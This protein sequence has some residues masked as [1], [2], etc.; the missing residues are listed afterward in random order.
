MATDLGQ[1]KS[2]SSRHEVF[3]EEQLRRV[4]N[5]IRLYDTATALLGFLFLTLTWVLGIVL[6]DRLLGMA[7]GTR[8][9]AWGLYA[10]VAALY[11]GITVVRPFLRPINPYFA[12]R[13]VE[14]VLPDA[15][16]SVINWLDLRQTK[17]PPA[18]HHSLGYRAARDLTDLD[19]DRTLSPRQTA[20]LGVL[21]VV[22]G[23]ALGVSLSMFRPTS[24]DL[25]EPIDR[26]SG[27]H[28][29]T[30]PMHQS[31]SFKVRVG[32]RVPNP[33]NPDRALKLLLRYHDD[34]P[35]QERPLER[36]DSDR[37]WQTR[38]PPAMVHS[39]FF[40][41]VTGGYAETPEYQVRVQPPPLLTGQYDVA[42]Q[43]PYVGS[44][45]EMEVGRTHANLKAV[46]GTRVT[47]VAHTNRPVKQ[48][49]LE[50]AP[51]QHLPESL[52]RPDPQALTFSFVLERDAASDAPAFVSGPS[53]VLLEREA[54]FGKYRIRF[55]AADG[56][57]NLDPVPYTAEVTTDQP[58]KVVL[59]K[60]TA[61]RV[62]ANGVLP[63]KGRATDD[64]GLTRMTLRRVVSDGKST[65]LLP[66]V[67]YREGK[68]QLE[69]GSHL[70]DVEYRDGLDLGKPGDGGEGQPLRLGSDVEFW[71]EA[72]DDY[73]YPGPHVAASEHYHVQ[74][75]AT[76]ADRAKVEAERKRLEAEKKTQEKALDQ[77]LADENRQRNG[78]SPKPD[79]KEQQR[80]D[81]ELKKDV[82]RLKEAM[83]QVE[84]EQQK[85]GKGKGDAPPKPEESAGNGSK[86]KTDPKQNPDPKKDGNPDQKPGEKDAN[87]PPKPDASQ[88]K[89]DKSDKPG[90][91]KQDPQGKGQPKPDAKPD[92]KAPKPD[93][94]QNQGGNRDDSKG[95]QKRNG[96]QDAKDV[97]KPEG[98]GNPKGQQDKG[99][100][101]PGKADPTKGEGQGPGKP[102]KKPGND[103]KD[104]GQPQ[105]G[106]KGGNEKKDNTKGPQ[107]G[108]GDPSKAKP[109][110]KP[111]DGEGQGQER[112]TH[113]KPKGDQVRE[114][115]GTGPG[116]EKSNDKM[117]PED[118]TKPDVMEI[119]KGLDSADKDKRADAARKLTNIAAK[120]T[121]PAVR[122]LCLE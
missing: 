3:V 54:T 97:K 12:A 71:L 86:D 45:P 62:P 66:P 93:A 61:T 5:R 77:Q 96:N 39:D 105:P 78:D 114:R 16:N 60:P 111:G 118:A 32:G 122:D 40:Y 31:I 101:G 52:P 35:Y 70:R 94:K 15:K 13:Q 33:D 107:K 57:G 74:I 88:P 68:L 67:P 109:D 53:R 98:K 11:L 87:K 47:L 4:R 113:E 42:Y 80:K 112:P 46:Q 115:P 8:L 55:E 99:K 121:D 65:R 85:P 100:P 90:D 25:L 14:Q 120:T 63:L 58:P 48:G 9:L 50:G 73:T 10:A 76:E 84:K 20:L 38:L 106:E 108:Q 92:E 89:D 44:K 59:E 17:L 116:G 91:T 51:G 79:E 103:G 34:E 28:N 24:I 36:G 95:D 37:D 30:V 83:K 27:D 43:Y 22:A 81:E 102:D 26:D 82:D 23:V 6:W 75:E 117:K 49:N 29:I 21:T 7:P 110:A 18:V 119:A 19:V 41:K 56:Q 69:D 72:A 1:T 2:S 104:K 64:H